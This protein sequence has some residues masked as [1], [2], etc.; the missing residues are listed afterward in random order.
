[1]IPYIRAKAESFDIPCD[2]GVAERTERLIII[3]IAAGFH[4]LG[5]PYFLAAGFWLLAVLGIVTVI[6]RL[7]VVRNGLLH[8]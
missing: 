5:V 4:G 2:V 1:M 6:Q 8:L 7:V 3:L